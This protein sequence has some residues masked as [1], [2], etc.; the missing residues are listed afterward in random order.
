MHPPLPLEGDLGIAK[1]YLGITLTSIAAKIYNALL[2]NCIEPKIEKILWRNQNGFQK[3]QST[4]LQILTIHR[5]LGVRAKNLDTTI[6]FVDF[7]KAFDGIHRRKIEQILLAFGQSKETFAAIIMLYKNTKVKIRFPDGDTDYFDILTGA[8]QGDT[9]APCCFI[10]CL[11]YVLRTSFNIM[12]DNG[13]KLAKERSRRYPTQTITDPDY[14][15][16]I[17]LLAIHPPKLN[18]SY[19]AWN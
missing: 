8:L 18:P 2:H 12:K 15:D 6:L 7:S 9:L 11:N 3:N 10:I 5:I 13:F 16:D 4:T 1:N 17:A 14:A 19:I